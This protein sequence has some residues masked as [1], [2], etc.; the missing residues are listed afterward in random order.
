VICGEKNISA[1]VSSAGV[2]LRRHEFQR[3]ASL[4]ARS[5]P[6]GEVAAAGSTPN[7]LGVRRQRK[8]EEVME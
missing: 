5:A 1:D 8:P 2:H 3:L 6:K 7:F 4:F